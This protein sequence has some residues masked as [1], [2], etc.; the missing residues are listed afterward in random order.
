MDGG[1]SERKWRVISGGK[2]VLVLVLDWPRVFIRG[3]SLSA[4]CRNQSWSTMGGYGPPGP[5]GP[6]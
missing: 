5:P 2:L 6:P 3:G 4:K 1:V